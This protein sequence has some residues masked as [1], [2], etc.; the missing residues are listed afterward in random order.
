MAGT[1]LIVLLFLQWPLRELFAAFRARPTIWGRWCSRCS[2]RSASPPRR[3]RARISRSTCWPGAIRRARGAC[4]RG[5]APRSDCCP[6]P[7]S[8]W[9]R[10]GPPWCRAWRVLEAFQDSGNPGYFLIK[11]ALWVM[12]AVIGQ[13]LVDLF[14]LRDERVMEWVGLA[15]L[16]LVGV[17]IVATGLPA[18]VILIAVATGRDLRRRIAGPSTSPLLGGAADPARQPVRE[19]PAAGAAALRDHG[20]CCWTGCRSPTRSIAPA[21]PRCRASPRRPLVSGMMLGALLGADERLGRRQ[22]A[23]RCRAWSR[24]GSPARACRRP[25]GTR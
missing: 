7:C 8:S 14:R 9:S 6:G 2:S 16:V 23:R 5:L 20:R 22:R 1:A 4:W 10:A 13:S 17:G 19:R 25:T 21:T 12:A 15:L 18:A 11:L 3:G 24:R